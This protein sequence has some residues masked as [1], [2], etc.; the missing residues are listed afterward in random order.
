[1]IIPAILTAG[2]RASRAA[3]LQTTVTDIDDALTKLARSRLP[4]VAWWWGVR[5]TD[6]HMGAHCYICDR[7]IVAGSLNVGITEDQ[8]HAVDDH[9]RSHWQTI[10]QQ[11]G[12]S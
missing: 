2:I 6:G 4:S 11:K 3:R 5:R 7:Q 12:T 10:L 1:M 9:R 8:A